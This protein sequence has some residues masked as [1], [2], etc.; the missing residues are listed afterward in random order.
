MSAHDTESVTKPGLH[1]VTDE[2]LAEFAEDNK[3]VDV[4]EVRDAAQ[5]LTL[6]DAKRII[7]DAIDGRQ[8]DPN[9]DQ[10]L[11]KRANAALNA[12]ALSHDVAVGLVEEIKLE[13]ALMD[14]TKPLTHKRCSE[15]VEVRSAVSNTDDFNMPVNTF[16]AWSI[17]LVF[18]LIG[19]GVNVFFSARNPGITLNTFCAQV[20]SFPL[21]KLMEKTLPTKSWTMF[22]RQWSFNPGPFNMKEHM[23]ITIMANVTFGGQV[24]VY[25][26][27]IIFVQRLPQVSKF[28]LPRRSFAEFRDRFKFFNH[29]WSLLFSRPS[30]STLGFPEW[31]FGLVLVI[32]LIF[33]IV[34]NEHYHTQ[35]QV[36]GLFCESSKKPPSMATFDVSHFAVCV[37]LGIIF[38][39]PVGIIMAI[40]NVEIT[41]NVVAE[42]IGGYALPGRPIAVNIFKTYGFISTAQAVGYAGDMK[43]GHYTKI[44]PRTLFSA[45]LIAS[46]FACFSGLGVANWQILNIKNIC[47]TAQ[48]S[49]FTVIWP[50]WWGNT[51]SYAGCDSTGCPCTLTLSA[52]RQYAGPNVFMQGLRSRTKDALAQ[53][54]LVQSKIEGRSSDMSILVTFGNMKYFDFSP[55]LVVLEEAPV[56]CEVSHVS[57]NLSL[58][59][60]YQ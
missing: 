54:R 38:V 27:D 13:A 40:T 5:H 51:V 52:T 21:A 11:L 10:G 19:S 14:D 33:G 58:P 34:A 35:M 22:G 37:A 9:F 48:V 43:L 23:L 26:T 47:T 57:L 53:H 31:W 46:I 4:K 60:S 20:L 55:L 12:E 36:W 30:T 1:E 2:K 29:R 45:Q 16:R 42:V 25:S 17:G 24:G 18:T 6:E 41:L 28:S 50:V 49:N 8:A 39:V 44:P 56:F 59:E 3:D 32:C 7:H 15:Q